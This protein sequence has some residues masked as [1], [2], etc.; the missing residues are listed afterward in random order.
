MFYHD[1]FVNWIYMSFILISYVDIYLMMDYLYTK[2][3]LKYNICL[4]NTQVIDFL[5]SI[6][7]DIASDNII[8]NW[9]FA[10]RD[11]VYCLE[12][13]CYSPGQMVW[14]FYI[15]N[16]ITTNN[17]L[18]WWK[19]TRGNK[20]SFSDWIDDWNPSNVKN[21]FPLLWFH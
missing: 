9:L 2:H 18:S 21:N 14:I 10:K 13:L 4:S 6:E 15:F 3:S 11:D 17:M 8:N 7:E 16:K 12:N 20:K 1:T 5:L 19:R